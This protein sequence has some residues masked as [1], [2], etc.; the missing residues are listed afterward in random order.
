MGFNLIF[1]ELKRRKSWKAP[2]WAIMCRVFRSEDYCLL[3]F[4][5]L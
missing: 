4:E 3:G 1:K 2:M 5:D